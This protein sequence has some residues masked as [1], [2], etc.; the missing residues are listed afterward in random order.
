MYSQKK[1]KKYIEHC[2]YRLVDG[3]VISPDA[4]AAG[5]A[6][7]GKKNAPKGKRGGGNCGNEGAA[8]KQKST[9]MEGDDDVEG[10]EEAAVDGEEA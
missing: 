1:F 3:M 6:G 7:T 8:K 9:E 10:A 2:G 4:A 5:D